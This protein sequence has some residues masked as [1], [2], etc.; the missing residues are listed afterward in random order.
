M[1]TKT[2]D[3][4]IWSRYAHPKPMLLKGITYIA[5]GSAE[6]GGMQALVLRRGNERWWFLLDTIRSWK[7]VECAC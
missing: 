3:V 4:T 6:S 5:C 7:V 2:Y 1:L